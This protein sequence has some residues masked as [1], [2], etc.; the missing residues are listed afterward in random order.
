[1]QTTATLTPAK[2]GGFVAL[3]PDTGTVSQGETEEE[4]LANLHDAGELY[5]EEFPPRAH[6]PQASR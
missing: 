5:R 3:D 1:M 4:A 2:E 6:P